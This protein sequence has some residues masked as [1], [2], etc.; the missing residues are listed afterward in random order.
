M[1]IPQN[2]K[3][4][5]EK[6]DELILAL[7]MLI[8]DQ[9]SR[10]LALEAIVVNMAGAE[11]VK[12]AD[13]KALIVQ[14]SKRFQQ[15]FEGASMTGFVERAQRISMQLSSNAKVGGAAKVVNKKSTKR[16]K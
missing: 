6:R 8:V 10:L 12:A 7:E 4:E 16:A 13:V 5:L 14:E 9:A 2:I 15:H 11:N 1:S 3:G